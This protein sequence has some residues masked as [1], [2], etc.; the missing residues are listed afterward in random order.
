MASVNRQTDEG[1][2]R[3]E[4]GNL[5]PVGVAGTRSGARK[6]R[7][8]VAAATPLLPHRRTAAAMT[9]RVEG[10]EAKSE[11]GTTEGRSGRV[12]LGG[13]SEMMKMKAHHPLPII[14]HF[15]RRRILGQ[16]VAGGKVR[17]DERV[18]RRMGGRR[19][20]QKRLW[21]LLRCPPR[22]AGKT[23]KISEQRDA[24]S[25]RSDE[26]DRAAEDEVQRTEAAVARPD[27][28]DG[29]RETEKKSGR[30]GEVEATLGID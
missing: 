20:T 24:E 23:K 9:G 29:A 30:G 21:L 16:S 25:E 14:L 18:E 10:G 6:A 15:P 13:E 11:A 19:R 7:D 3:S 22:K 4:V 1:S 26:S 2:A 5:P 8:D 27:A 28:G 12:G 17:R